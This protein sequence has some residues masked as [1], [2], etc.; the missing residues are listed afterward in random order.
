MDSIEH[1]LY[2]PIPQIKGVFGKQIGDNAGSITEIVS[3]LFLLYIKEYSF[4]IFYI[5]GFYINI[6][7]N[8]I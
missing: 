1:R 2:S 3:I 6:K 4:V 8:K 7:I 5:I